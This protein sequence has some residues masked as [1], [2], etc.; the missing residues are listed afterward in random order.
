[1]ARSRLGRRG[2]EA[3]TESRQIT[4]EAII[5]NTDHLALNL[6]CLAEM[7]ILLLVVIIA[8]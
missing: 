1:M 7:D 4:S 2:L 6:A 8:L 3:P 5:C